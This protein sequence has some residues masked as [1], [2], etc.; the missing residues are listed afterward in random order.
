[1]W[2]SEAGFLGLPIIHR[3]NS[4]F[5]LMRRADERREEERELNENSTQKISFCL[6][7][8]SY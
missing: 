5:I 7:L 3:I 2:Y 4:K 1:M 8:L 6:V